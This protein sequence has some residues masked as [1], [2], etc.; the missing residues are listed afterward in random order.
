MPCFGFWLIGT[1]GHLS[2]CILA[3]VSSY[4]FIIWHLCAVFL[5][6][7]LMGASVHLAYLL[8]TSAI[9]AY[10]VI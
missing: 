10:Q 5:A 3:V 8:Y 1:S 2:L 6:T 7:S 9:D 4:G